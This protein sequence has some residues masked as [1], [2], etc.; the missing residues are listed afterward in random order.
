MRIT[1][2]RP[3]MTKTDNKKGGAD[4]KNKVTRRQWNENK[5]IPHRLLLSSIEERLKMLSSLTATT[6]S[7]IKKLT[8]VLQ[9]GAAV[10]YTDIKITPLKTI[11]LP[12]WKV[13][14]SEYDKICQYIMESE[15]SLKEI[16]KSL[17]EIVSIEDDIDTDDASSSSTPLL[18]ITSRPTEPDDVK[19]EDRD[20]EGSSY[21]TEVSVPN[22]ANV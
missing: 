22:E 16:N 6:N 9:E 4:E 21:S 15:E 2:S 1:N 10:S 8:D 5:E 18:V 17:C 11:Q 7:N 20:G 3:L 19:M 12:Q 14:S 13:Y